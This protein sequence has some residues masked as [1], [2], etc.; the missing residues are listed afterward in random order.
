MQ[1]TQL[2]LYCVYTRGTQVIQ[3]HNNNCF[4][5]TLHAYSRNIPGDTVFKQYICLHA[6]RL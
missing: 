4:P 2:G 6:L 5:R 1:D 3:V